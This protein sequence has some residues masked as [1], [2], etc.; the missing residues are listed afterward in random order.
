LKDRQEQ[1]FDAFQ[2]MARNVN[3]SDPA[4]IPEL[5]RFSLR[6]LLILVAL[7]AIVLVPI[8]YIRN[9]IIRERAELEQLEKQNEVTRAR[10]VKDVMDLQA[11]LGRPPNDESE[12]VAL[13][14]RPMPKVHLHSVPVQIRYERRGQGFELVHLSIAD[15]YSVFHSSNPG[16]GWVGFN[17]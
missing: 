7:V 9:Q 10:I 15:D 2:P 12:L 17:N 13:L 1:S 8:A 14:G 6:A 3:I 11:R 4:Y 16:A 5:P